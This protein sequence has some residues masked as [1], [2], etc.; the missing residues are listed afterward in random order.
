MCADF[1]KLWLESFSSLLPPFSHFIADR[2]F[3][4]VGCY[5]LK[6]SLSYI[7]C[8]IYPLRLIVPDDIVI[9]VII[10]DFCLVFACKILSSVAFPHCS[11]TIPHTPL[12]FPKTNCR[13]PH[14][15]SFH[16]LNRRKHFRFHKKKR[17]KKLNKDVGTRRTYIYM[18]SGPRMRE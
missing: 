8:L 14:T 11:S 9:L 5:F 10:L 13:Q 1:F 6:L 12:S 7:I 17:E 15:H 16:K 18:A 2:Q 3:C 4:S